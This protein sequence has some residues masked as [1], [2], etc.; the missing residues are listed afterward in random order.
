VSGICG[1]KK[2]RESPRLLFL[3]FSLSLPPSLPLRLD[4]SFDS[5]SKF[6]PQTCWEAG[7]RGDGK[8]LFCTSRTPSVL[9][10]SLSE[11]LRLIIN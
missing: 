5:G 10:D 8:A 1:R 7:E 2:K 3:S 11:K 4:R 6:P 9:P